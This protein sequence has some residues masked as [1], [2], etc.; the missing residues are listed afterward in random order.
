MRLHETTA[1]QPS[2]RMR[3]AELFGSIQRA[4]EASTS[5]SGRQSAHA[6]AVRTAF[7][8]LLTAS[9]EGADPIGMAKRL[10]DSVPSMKKDIASIFR[11][12]TLVVNLAAREHQSSNN[13]S[14]T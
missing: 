3:A 2:I 7:E 1:G 6:G 5:E 4:Q 14:I 8:I 13:R 11:E 10:T 12:A 9:N